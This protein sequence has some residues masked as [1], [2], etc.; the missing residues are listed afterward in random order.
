MNGKVRA[1]IGGWVFEPWRGLFYPRGLKRAGELAYA[2][3]RLGALEI[4]VTYQSAQTPAIF[5]AW[6]AQTP[7]T[8][9]FTV[10][11]SRT[12]TN[13]RVL[14]DTGEA[15][16]RFLG[17]GLTALGARL[18]PILWQFMPTKRF[19]RDDFAA[20]L[21]LLPDRRD[22]LRLR[23]CVEARHESFIDDAFVDL[24]RARGVAICLTDS[25]KFPMI[26]ADTADFAY[27]R[28][29]R[30]EDHIPTGYSP[31][32]LDAW[33][34][35]LGALSRGGAGAAPREVFAFFISAGKMRAPA[36]AMALTERLAAAS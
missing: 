24:C 3:A 27:A 36:A 32:A 16:E 13:R 18:G 11:A 17:Q 7:E 12:C 20:F 26:A 15:V 25:P 5:A 29:M 33:A 2:S 1:G 6:A 30:G 9:I 19:D 8:F 23:H 31:E 14:A 22:G 35:R 4:N 28:L 10:K 21:D 34:A